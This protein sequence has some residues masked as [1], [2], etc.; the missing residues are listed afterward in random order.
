MVTTTF[1][2]VVFTTLAFGTFM[3]FM[4]RVLIP[5]KKSDLAEEHDHHHD[6][7]ASYHHV[8]EHPNEDSNELN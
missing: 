8:Y 3:S 1:A 4:G 6:P 5:P 7:N 2:L